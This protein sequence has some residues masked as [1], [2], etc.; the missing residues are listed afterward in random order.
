MIH[1]AQEN[2]LIKGLVPE[3]VDNGIAVLQYADDTIL[4]LEN[5]VQ[6]VE[7]M[8]L[9]LGF[10]EKM[11]GLKINFNKSEALMVSHD[12]EKA[13][14][15]ADLMNC[16]TGVWLIKYLGVPVTSSKLHVIDWLPVEEKM[17]K[18]LD[19]WKGSALSFG[20]KLILINS[21]L[22]SIPTY[23][24][25]MYLLPKTILEKMDKTRKK[26]FWQGGGEKKKYHLVKWDKI[27][28]PKKKGGFRY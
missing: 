9:L 5:E 25:S 27:T 21:S 12:C 4:C 16:A 13:I 28:R 1:T 22:S 3:Y 17:V 7:N 18:R 8:K 10:Y 23:Y 6:S 11:S 19:G 26:F 14:E 20:G 24:M 2:G 15:F